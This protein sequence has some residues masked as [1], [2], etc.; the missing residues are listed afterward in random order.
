[1]PADKDPEVDATGA[2]GLEL[3][4]GTEAAGA[5][6]AVAADEVAVAAG[7]GAAQPSSSSNMSSNEARA[8]LTRALLASY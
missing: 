8:C 2:T 7:L 3:K 1:M 4:V 5:F 6:S